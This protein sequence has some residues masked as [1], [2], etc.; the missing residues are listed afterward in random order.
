MDNSNRESA[1]IRHSRVILLILALFVVTGL[2]TGC[3]IV[4]RVTGRGNDGAA[5]DSP[6]EGS[7]DGGSTRTVCKFADDTLEEIS[8]LA[9]SIK[10][11]GILWAHNDSGDGPRIYAVNNTTCKIQA[12]IALGGVDPRDVEA[13]AMGRNSAGDPVIWVGDIG[14]NQGTWPSVRLYRIPEPNKIKNQTVQ[15]KTYN[16][17]YADGPRDAEGLLVDPRPGGRIWI[18]SKRMA[19][20]SGLYALPKSFVSD[21]YGTAKR[22]G[23]VPAMTTDASFAPNGES[24]V[25]RTYLG[26]ELFQGT[27]PGVDGRTI[28][29]PL[30]TQGEAI[31]FSSAGTGFYV[32]SEGEAS[33]WFVPLD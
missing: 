29:L 22:V 31:T 21:G 30:Q 14:D 12:T 19:A 13:I 7:H 9:A 10:H 27:P 20:E 4:D 33:L 18:A 1:R 32:A 28:G 16:V 3:G 2:L 11:P 26:A 8:G 5:T 23:S 25:I 24:F 6:P 17:T 15:A